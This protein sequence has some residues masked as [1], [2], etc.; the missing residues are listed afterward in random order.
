MRE[1]WAPVDTLFVPALV[2]LLGHRVLKPAAR[3]TLVSYG[4]EVLD[5]LAYFLKDRDE[6]VWVRRHIPSVL[7]L[8]PTQR[9]MNVLLDALD[10]PDGFLRYKAVAAIEKLRRDHSN[11]GPRAR[12][13]R[14]AR[15]EGDGAVLPVPD[16]AVQPR[17]ERTPMRRSRCSCARSTTSSTARSIAFTACW[18]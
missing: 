9:S 18:A 4:D 8:L 7:A 1:R 17:P 6:H 15:A 12:T 13:N 10:D 16:A 14:G 2:S 3:D 11:S 5:A